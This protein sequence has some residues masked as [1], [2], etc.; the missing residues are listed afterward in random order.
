MLS[1]EVPMKSL[2]DAGISVQECARRA[3]EGTRRVAATTFA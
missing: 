3:L 1:P 2:R